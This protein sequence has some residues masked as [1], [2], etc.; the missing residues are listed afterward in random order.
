[1]ASLATPAGAIT[2]TESMLNKLGDALSSELGDMN[3]YAIRRDWNRYHEASRDCCGIEKAL[4]ILG[5]S[6][7]TVQ[8]KEDNRYAAVKIGDATFPVQTWDA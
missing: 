8:R 1:M 4:R 2:V 6:V 3:L 7:E 5:V